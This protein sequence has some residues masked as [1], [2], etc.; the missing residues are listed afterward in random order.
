MSSQD[1]DVALFNDLRPVAAESYAAGQRK[2][3][4]IYLGWAAVNTGA[5]L[6]LVVLVRGTVSGWLPLLAIAGLMGGGGVVTSYLVCKDAP[7]GVQNHGVWFKGLS[8]RGWLGWVIG[9]GMTVFYTV[10]YVWK[11]DWGRNPL[12]GAIDLLGPLSQ[13]L[14]GGPGDRWFLYGFVYTVVVLV[15]GVRS[16]MKYRQSR[17]HQ[18]RTGSVVFF[19]L[20]FAFLLPSLL[21]QFHQAEFYFSYFWPLKP[22]YL[23]PF[24]VGAVLEGG[25]LGRAMILWGV[26]ASFVAVPLLTYFFGKR[27]YCS[28][29]CL[30]KHRHS[31]HGLH[32]TRDI[33]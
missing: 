2:T 16:A 13:L 8:R 25:S 10:L 32:G 1:S 11:D 31:D 12:Q 30:R 7:E 21:Q 33:K 20:G 19:Q 18:L 6:L 28:W 26:L 15:Y 22:E 29:V 5:V 17:Y 23:L 27:W 3:L 4:P 24:S 14:R 9:L